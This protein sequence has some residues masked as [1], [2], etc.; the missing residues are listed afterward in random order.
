MPNFQTFQMCA[1]RTILS[2]AKFAAKL[3]AELRKL[4]E[5]QRPTN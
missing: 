5:I 4:P 2:T 3:Q 1:F